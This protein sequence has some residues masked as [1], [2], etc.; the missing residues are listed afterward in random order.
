LYSGPYQNETGSDRIGDTPYIDERYTPIRDNY[1]LMQP[2]V[3]TP[4][5]TYT[6][7]AD[8]DEGTLLYVEHET[9]PD[10]LQLSENVTS[11][12][13]IWV[14]NTYEGTVSKVDTVTGREVGRYWV[15]DGTDSSPSRTTVDL[16]GNCWVGCRQRGT[17]VKIG[18]FEAGQWI[19]RN[20]DGVCQTSQDANSD[21]EISG[22]EMLPWGQDECVLYE[23]VLVPGYEGAYIPGTYS[24]PYDYDY[25]GVSPRGL[26]VDVS[27]NLW[28]GTWSTSRYF[29]IHGA[30][31]AIL[32]SVDVAPHN[33]Y[34]AAIDE[35]GILW[36]AEGPGSPDG[37]D[38]LLLRLDPSTDAKS[39]VNLGHTCYGLGLDYNHHLW[40]SSYWE[41]KLSRIDISADPPT[42]V[43]YSTPEQI[44][45]RGVAATSDNNIWVANTGA[46]TVT[47]YNNDGNLIATIT[48]LYGPTGV[49]VD[50]SGM[51]WA[52]DYYDEYL[53]RIDPASNTIDLSK[54]IVGSGGHYTYSDMTGIVLRT[55]TTKIGTWTVVFDSMAEGTPWGTI[56]WNSSEPVGT[57]ITVK[58]RSSDNKID[59]SEWEGAANGVRLGSTPNG[60]YL[61]IETAFHMISGIV[62]PILYDLTVA[63]GPGVHNVGITNGSPCKTVVG[64]GYALNVNVT[65]ANQGDF[66]ETFDVILFAQSLTTVNEAGLVGYWKFD[67]GGGT[68]AY[69]SSGNGK[70][71]SIYGA[72]WTDG[73]CGKALSLDGSDD[74]IVVGNSTTLNPS[75]ALT[76]SA[77]VFAK[78]YSGVG[79]GQRTIV[80][81]RFYGSDDSY[82]LVIL[83]EGLG[84]GRV[85]FSVWSNNVERDLDSADAVPLDQW[86]HVAATYDGGSA[87]IYL[88]GTQNAAAN[89]SGDIDSTSINTTIGAGSQGTT[90]FFNGTIDEVRIY[91]RSLSAEEIAVIAEADLVGTR[92]AIQKQTVTLESGA[93]TTLNLAWNTSGFAMGDY[94][95]SVIAAPV[96]G[97][98]DMADNTFVD[99]WVYV[100]IP[101][102]INADGIVEMMDFY[103]ASL[104]FGSTP[105]SPNWNPNADVNADGIVEMMDFF[106][107]SQHFGEHYP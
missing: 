41:Y 4:T 63:A 1:P 29:Y 8:F 94:I 35:N 18:L 3:A 25:W 82:Q 78:S 99:G 61:Q 107:L 32:R 11:L 45:S 69:D 36:S 52:T 106:V 58:V 90:N 71:G 79:G 15:S 39:F 104:A 105:T 95:I 72:A 14:P 92:G 56:S 17:V 59:W 30:T 62:S 81:R 70:R 76:I 50:I 27:N 57:S 101:G 38:R 13:F 21:G 60:R 54:Q 100:G 64:Q 83:P 10:Q 75:T 44:E 73:K 23:V 89:I 74:Y 51:V 33:A 31:C 2:Y 19:D 24:G 65:A 34:G 5:R 53:H 88:N 55:I 84:E 9:E 87:K 85:R 86:C 98:T 77:W 91:S 42:F 26:A 80:E 40:V 67:E 103:Y 102:D 6:L 37:G 43:T 47:R 48:G 93:S 28:A 7:D 16:L 97:E 12:P 49:S 96:P 22:G 68:T 46:N 20:G 66:T